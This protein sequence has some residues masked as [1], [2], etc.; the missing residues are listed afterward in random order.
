VKVEPSRCAG[1]GNSVAGHFGDAGDFARRQFDRARPS[2]P[3]LPS[4]SMAAV[5]PDDFGTGGSI[6]I[7]SM[8]AFLIS[9]RFIAGSDKH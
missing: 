1:G 2:Q 4:T 3:A 6:E 8:V 9:R 7:T 5:G